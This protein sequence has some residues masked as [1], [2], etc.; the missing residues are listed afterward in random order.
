[1]RPLPLWRVRC[2]AADDVAGRLAWF[3]VA[4]FSGEALPKF[5]AWRRVSPVAER[6]SLLRSL[7]RVRF[8]LAW[9][10]AVAWRRG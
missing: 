9:A 10:G 7:P 5:T 8:A 1:V 2:G 6:A 3:Q 4:Q